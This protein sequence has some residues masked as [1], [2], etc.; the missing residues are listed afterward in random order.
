MA[1]SECKCKSG[2]KNGR[3]WIELCPPC[4]VISD[5]RH[6]EFVADMKARTAAEDLI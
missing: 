5:A 6:E 4:K 2:T 3:E 1:S